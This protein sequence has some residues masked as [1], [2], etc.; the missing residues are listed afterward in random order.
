MNT[1][2]MVSSNWETRWV[3]AEGTFDPVYERT[4][5]ALRAW[6]DGMEQ[7]LRAGASSRH[8]G[9]SRG[10]TVIQPPHRR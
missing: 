1:S 10:L 9:L 4:T 3:S 2:K 6:V 8:A 7:A 5:A